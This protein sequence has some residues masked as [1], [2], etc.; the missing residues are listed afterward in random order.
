MIMSFKSMKGERAGVPPLVINFANYVGDS[1]LEAEVMSYKNE[2]GQLYTI[3]GFK[4]YIGNLQFV[5]A[6]GSAYTV[7]NY[8]LVNALDDATT[9]I[10]L[11]G[12]PE[13]AYTSIRFIIGVDSAHNCSGPQSGDLDPV[14]G[15][16][17]AWNTGYIF[18]KLDGK[19]PASKAPG[20]IFEFHI[21]GYKAPNNCIRAISLHFPYPM[22]VE[23]CKSSVLTIKADAAKVMD[24]QNTIDLSK[25]YSVTDYHN[26]TL[27]ADNYADMFSIAGIH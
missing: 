13:G 7:D 18:M 23:N 14:N 12:V 6:D 19:S 20:H 17:W 2:S 25:M 10:K 27:I 16:F 11:Y 26:A 4:Y 8:F 24:N 22:I 1:A 15:M 21:G 3:S 9:H 5:R